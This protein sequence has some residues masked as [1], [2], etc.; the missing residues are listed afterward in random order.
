VRSS[1]PEPVKDLSSLGQLV[2]LTSAPVHEGARIA[3]S[4]CNHV[5]ILHDWGGTV[6]A[7]AWRMASLSS[8]VNLL[9]TPL[10]RPGPGGPPFSNGLPLGLRFFCVFLTLTGVRFVS[11]VSQIEALAASTDLSIR[12]MSPM[13]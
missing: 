8:P 7:A 9:G 13:S 11:I 3:T 5:G 10:G 6:G 4:A 1:A 2:F 12:Q